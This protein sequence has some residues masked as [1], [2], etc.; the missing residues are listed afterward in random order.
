MEVQWKGHLL[1]GLTSSVSEVCRK[2]VAYDGPMDNTAHPPFA[3]DQKHAA[4]TAPSVNSYPWCCPCE[5]FHG[6]CLT[7]SIAIWCLLGMMRG[8]FSSCWSSASLMRLLTL[9]RP[10]A[11]LKRSRALRGLLFG[12]FSFFLLPGVL[13]SI[14]LFLNCVDDGSL[15]LVHHR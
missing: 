11:S 3:T 15:R 5:F 10:S 4:H 7:R 12:R 14:Y 2:V 1:E 8:A 13:L 6:N 9:S